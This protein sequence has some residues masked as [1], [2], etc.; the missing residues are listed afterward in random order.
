MRKR[1]CLY[2]L[3]IA[4]LSCFLAGCGRRQLSPASKAWLYEDVP[5]PTPQTAASGEG[6]ETPMN[7]DAH[8]NNSGDS[9]HRQYPRLDQWERRQLQGAA[10]HGW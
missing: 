4:V 9:H 7:A 8:T 3:L 5:S 10:G 6:T 1:I 2:V